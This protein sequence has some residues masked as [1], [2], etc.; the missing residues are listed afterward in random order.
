[1][2]LRSNVTITESTKTMRAMARQT[3]QGRWREAFLVSLA[4]YAITTLPSILFPYISNSAFTLSAVNV[5]T[6]M[7]SGPMALG[8]SLYFLKLFR[9]RPAGVEDLLRGFNYMWKSFVLLIL[10]AVRIFLFSL[11]LIIPGILAA[12]RYS[13]AFFIMADNPEKTPRQCL[14]ESGILMQD[15]RGRFF[16]LELSFIGWGLLASLPP[17]LG[18][19][20]WGLDHFDFV[21]SPAADWGDIFVMSLEAAAQPIHPLFYLLGIGTV[22]LGVYMTTAHACFYDL[23]NGNLQVRKAEELHALRED[24]LPEAQSEPEVEPQRED[25]DV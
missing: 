17:A 10:M 25:T 21:I 8:I 18:Q 23:A 2:N 24:F 14:W 7:V 6:L 15:N 13:Q 3:L 1:M 9:Q 5:Y 16:V 4:M 11:L 12:L 19:M 22:F 20:L